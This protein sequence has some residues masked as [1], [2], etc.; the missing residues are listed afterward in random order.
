MLAAEQIS[1]NAP[2]GCRALAAANPLA[3]KRAA[4][5]AVEEPVAKKA[6]AD[7]EE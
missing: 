7:D 2:S 3:A 4:S 1:R 6:R 5:S